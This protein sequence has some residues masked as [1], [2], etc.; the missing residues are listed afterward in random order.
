M[1]RLSHALVRAFSIP[2]A[3]AADGSDGSLLAGSQKDSSARGEARSS[4]EAPRATKGS[5]TEP[6]EA[7]AKTTSA[8]TSPLH[9]GNTDSKSLSSQIDGAGIPR[10]ASLDSVDSTAPLDARRSST[11]SAAG[12]SVLSLDPTKMS[13]K[14]KSAL[15]KRART[16]A[17]YRKL[18]VLLGDNED[19]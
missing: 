3:R 5:L 18:Q 14:R 2:E 7:S 9:R 16:A 6:S 11:F 19:D 17:E 12:S 15:L 8:G 10:Q 1:R 4:M 13:K